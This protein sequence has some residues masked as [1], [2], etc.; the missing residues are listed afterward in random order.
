MLRDSQ[1]FSM[2]QRRMGFDLIRSNPNLCGYN[3][4]GMLDHGITGEGMWT[5]WREWKPGCADVLR[6]GWAPLRW[7]LF[8]NPLH[9]YARRPLRVE[10]VLATE[11]VLPPG[12]YSAT[13]RILGPRGIAWEKTVPFQM[14]APGCGRE[15][16]LS[17][18]VL[19]EEVV[20][21]GP[22]GS[23][24][25]AARLDKGGCP[26]G[27]RMKFRLSD[28]Q[29]LPKVSATV[30]AWGLDA[31]TIWWLD[32]HGVKCL[33]WDDAAHKKNR[34]IVVGLPSDSKEA[35][36]AVLRDEV[37][38]GRTAVFLQPKAFA[39]GDDSTHWLP[40]EKK[41]VCKTFHDWLY[42]KDCVAKRHAIFDGLQA[43]AI[44]DWDY[45]DQ[46]I[47]H[48]IFQGQDTP[49]ETVVAA[50]AAGYTCPGG[51]DCGVMVGRFKLGAGWLVLNTLNVLNQLDK[52]PAAD[53]LLL[54]LVRY[55][56]R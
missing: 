41:G 49:D 15:A 27:D 20:L 39:L 56:E 32:A 52:H 55:T 19:N 35:E 47:G 10:A 29:D 14:A 37:A 54:N 7:C 40:L 38:Q 23:Y 21:D 4:T 31:R 12:A 26:A 9:G 43:G 24:E 30:T 13:F 34:V 18:P 28:A 5:F 3:L 33:P 1:R 2:R 45:Y 53:R 8:V 44:L 51:Y 36:W 6:D 25:L 46:L 16:P 50:F 11:D 42:H 17:V 48:E 22:A